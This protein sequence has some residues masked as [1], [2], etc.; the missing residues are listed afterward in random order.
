MEGSLEII[1][2]NQDRAPGSKG[3]RLSTKADELYTPTGWKDCV[4]VGGWLHPTVKSVS[5]SEKGHY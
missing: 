1:E 4:R 2:G 5:R 3:E